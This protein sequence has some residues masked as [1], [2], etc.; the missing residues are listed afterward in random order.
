[1]SLVIIK[2]IIGLI[3][4][5]TIF[6]IVQDSLKIKSKSN[7]KLIIVI[8]LMS[9]PTIIFYQT[10]YNAFVSLLTYIFSI[11]LIK[12]YFKISLLSSIFIC[13][14]SILLIAII[15]IIISTINSIFLT[16]EELRTLKYVVITNNILIGLS[17]YL[18]SKI[19]IIKNKINYLYKRIEKSP[20]YN[21][22]TFTIIC[23]L[24]TIITFFNITEIFKLNIYYLITISS[25]FVLFLLYYFYISELNNY[26]KLNDKYNILFDY[27]QTFED[28]IDNEQLYRHEL[29]NNLS[30]IR[31]MT[32]NKKIINKIDNML[33]M[34]I[35]IDDEYVEILKY[36]P[37]GG[38]KGLLYYKI[39]LA[40]S[41]NV[42]IV[43]EIS[44]KVTSRMKK[45]T[46]NKLRQI[47]IVIG[48]Y[49]DNA[50]EAAAT[51]K[52]KL[53]TLEIYE[54]NSNIVF[55]ISNTYN[56]ML[57]IKDMNKKGYTTKGENHGK[58]LYYVSKI[59]RKY[60]WLESSQIYL[61]DFFIQKL[62]VK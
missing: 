23:I 38:L 7:Y 36:I 5:I 3:M 44:S 28:W 61:N 27:V 15:D 47:G 59:L 42:N 6:F 37:K 35:N 57:S 41:E 8:I 9:L 22:I 19:P 12:K 53:I 11:V 43:I 10:E 40:K 48:I 1:M 21:I 49:L 52:K 32:N 13:G 24:T 55:V 45:I 46:E 30:M 62:S 17:A 34:N 29:K 60:K 14:Y 26:E 54:I 51:S 33:N 58:G 25:I 4:A 18:V 39:A 2:V 56:K 31:N 16:Y 20:N 50:I